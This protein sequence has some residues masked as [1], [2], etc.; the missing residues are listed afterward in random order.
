[1]QENLKDFFPTYWEIPEIL[2]NMF[3]FF[4]TA[5]SLMNKC[6]LL[7]KVNDVFLSFNR[8]R[9]GMVEATFV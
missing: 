3:S 5:V 6:R 4:F 8:Q 9:R 2:G 1:M 7:K